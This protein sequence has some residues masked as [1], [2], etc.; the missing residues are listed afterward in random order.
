[1]ADVKNQIIRTAEAA[2]QKEGLLDTPQLGSI[3]STYARTTPIPVVESAWAQIIS[4]PGI[5][6][7]TALLALIF[8]VLSIWYPGLSDIAKVFAGAV[9]G[10]SGASAKR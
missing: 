4:V 8:G 3:L 1:L 2:A 7:I 9:V 5:I 6:W 10:A